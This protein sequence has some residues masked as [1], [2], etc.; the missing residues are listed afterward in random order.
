[1]NLAL[2]AMTDPLASPERDVGLHSLRRPGSVMSRTAHGT[3]W[4]I[5]WRLATRALG[6]ISTLVLVRL[7]APS[8]FGIVTLTM[9]FAH[10]L[11]ALSEFGI[12]N[13]IIRAD[14]HDRALYDTG[15]T[16]NVLRG[17]FVAFMLLVLAIPAAH[18]FHSPHLTELMMV[19]AAGM[20]FGG[21][22]NIGIVDFKRFIAFDQ[23]FRLKIIPRVVS[24]AT[25]ISLAFLLRN[26]WALIIAILVNQSLGLVMSYW[27]HPYRPRFT[28]SAWRRIASYSM[29]LWFI[30]LAG[31]LRV[32]GTNSLIGKLATMGAVGI[33]GVG[34]E[35]AGLPTAELVG[36]LT[37]AAFAGFAEIRKDGNDGAEM[38]MR[39]VGI[40]I[41][42]TLPAGVGL[43]LIARPLVE[44]ALGNKWI[45]AIPILQ[46]LGISLS[47]TTF[48]R[49]VS[50]LFSVHAWLKPLIII[51]ILRAF[52]QFLLLALLLPNHGLVGAAIAVAIV[53]IAAQIVF[54]YVA[55]RRLNIHLSQLVMQIW[56]SVLACAVMA[57]ILTALGRGWAIP[58]LLPTPTVSMGLRLAETV[59]LGGTIYAGSVSLLW[60]LTGRTQGP[61]S[62]FLGQL[63]NLLKRFRS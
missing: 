8:D 33:F 2:C 14:K 4:V 59:L 19:A 10:S 50:T 25:A 21:F 30:S 35:I 34:R 41:L 16:I 6:L 23:E 43:S 31:L 22:E 11:S 53:E 55:I 5:G 38:L 32:L 47:L 57:A 18:F 26:F 36:P 49:V 52:G 9:S 44:I 20:F 15:F 63:S 3:G 12:E 27:I 45:E 13:A 54:I 62:D 40:M 1:M 58:T 29:M 61:E 17:T 7:L 42:I 60:L 46:I 39:M 48:G 51:N 56:R 24:V 28:L 37:R